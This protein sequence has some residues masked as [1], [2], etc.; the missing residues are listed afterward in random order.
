MTDTPQC[1]NC[2]GP[3]EPSWDK[4]GNKL[5]FWICPRECI[6]PHMHYF[7]KP[8]GREKLITR[9]EYESTGICRER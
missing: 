3:M 9:G 2:H 8:T 4:D 7:E 1:P 6:G 5:I